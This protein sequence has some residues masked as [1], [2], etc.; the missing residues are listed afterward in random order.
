[1]KTV[2]RDAMTQPFIRHTTD[3]KQNRIQGCN[4]QAWDL[5]QDSYIFYPLARLFSPKKGD[6]YGDVQG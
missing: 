2:L 5:L 1:M 6:F 4:A 3:G